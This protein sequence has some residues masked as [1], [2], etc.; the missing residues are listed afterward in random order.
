[1]YLYEKK[2][3]KINVYELSPIEKLIEEYKR[4]E[5]RKKPVTERVYTAKSNMSIQELPLYNIED[6]VHLKDLQYEDMFFFF[7]W[8]HEVKKYKD[9]DLAENVLEDY[10]KN[11][12]RKNY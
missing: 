7:H 9:L 5:I 6:I 1:M 4:K 11:N 3:N 8:Y 10:Y 2:D 12:N